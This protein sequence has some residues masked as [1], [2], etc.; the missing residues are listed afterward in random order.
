MSV[1]TYFMG[2]SSSLHTSIHYVRWHSHPPGLAKLNF[3]VLLINF[4]AT[5]VFILQDWV[6][7]LL[8]AVATYYGVTTILVAEARLLRDEVYVAMQAG[9]HNLS[10]E[11]DKIVI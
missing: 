9:Y 5:D 4:S 1:D 6:D 8:K 11:G 3:D 2:A 7:R 10:V